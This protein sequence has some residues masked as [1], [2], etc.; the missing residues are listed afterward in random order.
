[1]LKNI[2]P[3][4]SQNLHKYFFILFLFLIANFF[5]NY[6]VIK[7]TVLV[8]EVLYKKYFSDKTKIL[9]ENKNLKVKTLNYTTKSN[10]FFVIET[11]VAIITNEEHLSFF[12]NKTNYNDAENSHLKKYFIDEKILIPSLETN[13]QNTH[14]VSSVLSPKF[15]ITITESNSIPKTFRA[16]T[17][18]NYYAGE[19]NYPLCV[20]QYATCHFISQKFKPTI[21]TLCTKI[22]TPPQK[23]ETTF[24]AGVGD[25]MLARGV[26]DTLINE[27]NGIEKIFT[28]TLPILQSNDIMIGNLEGAVTE[29]KKNLN[30]TYTFKFKKEVL[31]PIKNAGFNYLMLTN[32]HCYDYGEEGFK[33][34]L[35]ALSEYNI[36]TSGAGFNKKEASQFYTINKNGQTFSIISCGFY[37]VER[38]G[39]NGAKQATATKTRAGILWGDTELL[40]IVK[41]EKAKGNFIIVNVHGGNEYQTFPSNAQRQFYQALCD[42]GADIIFGSHPHVLQTTEWYNGSLIAYSLGNFIFNGM[43]MIPYATKSEILR[44]GIHNGKI[45]YI[46]K[47]PVKLNGKTV[48][49][50]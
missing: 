33:D 22:F 27:K 38:S 48:S 17:A 41:T 28:S 36:A 5:I 42:N 50:E 12:E 49:L 6:K 7:Y 29:H 2:K 45:L 37:P 46:E 9:F 13:F 8:D 4:N 39:F 11:P 3:Y 18:N 24:V 25:M 40:E 16:I 21:E 47:Y 20:N 26:Q 35:N 34:T 30:K 14:K 32:N 31:A 10:S 44:L 43:G 23:K 19:K 1:M 15:S